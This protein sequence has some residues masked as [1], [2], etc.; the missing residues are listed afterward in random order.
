MAE[1]KAPEFQTT[2]GRDVFVSYAS[3]DS[4]VADAVVAALE[5]NSVK[6]WVAPRDVRAGDSYAAAIVEAIN[7]CRMLVLILSQDAINSPHV[8]RE[9]ERASSK[10]R[11]ILSV[12]MDAAKLPPDLEYFLSANQWLDASGGPVGKI[13]PALIESV[14]NRDGGSTPA[15]RPESAP[16]SSPAPRNPSPRWRTRVTA[17]ALVVAAIVVI[18]A[19]YFVISRLVSPQRLAAVEVTPTVPADSPVPGALPGKSVAV[20]PFVNLSGG[21]KDSYLGDGISG[22]ILSALSKLSGLKVIGRAS[23]FQFR[24]RDVDA[25][26]VGKMLNVRSLLTGTVQRAG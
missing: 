18:V 20:L 9:V 1:Y 19:G 24:D 5:Q 8:L 3:Q 2:P 12:R 13:L 4:S 25:V 21:D 11:P 6:C 15:A 10:R 26:K 17:T 23:S 22:E 14:R 7:S 16:A